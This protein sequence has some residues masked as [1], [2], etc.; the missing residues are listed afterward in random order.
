M[1]RIQV[2]LISSN[3]VFG[4][5]CILD[6]QII[7]QRP[8]GGESWEGG[9]VEEIQWL[10]QDEDKVMIIW[11]EGSNMPIVVADNVSASLRNM[12]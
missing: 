4:D 1:L 11:S 8:T 2:Y 3:G 12:N 5:T 10:S 9:T 6:P 7:I